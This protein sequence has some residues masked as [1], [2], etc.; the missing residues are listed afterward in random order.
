MSESTTE[1]AAE[2]IGLANGTIRKFRATDCG[3]LRKILE[4]TD[5]F[6]DEEIEVAV[7]LMEA[8]IADPDQLDYIHATYEDAAGVIRGYYCYGPTPM[9]VSTFDMYWI[10]VD[11]DVQGSGIGGA[12]IRH[13]E[14]NIRRSGGTLVVV[15][16]SSLPK[17][18]PTRRFYRRHAY[19]E[20]A[21]L[22]DYYGP[23]DDLMIFTKHL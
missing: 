23:D 14:E 12:L 20:S 19:V 6:R 11:P 9:T 16:T 13:C 2:K 21:R 22:R 4:A 15:E 3:P 10:A 5:V 18:E 17:Y 1:T 7:E 8:D